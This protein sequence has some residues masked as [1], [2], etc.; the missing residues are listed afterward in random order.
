[1]FFVSYFFGDGEVKDRKSLFV[2]SCVALKTKKR[3]LPLRK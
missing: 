1:M 2:V 3:E